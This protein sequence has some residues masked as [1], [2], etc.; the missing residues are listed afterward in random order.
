[1]LLLLRG[2][3][4]LFVTIYSYLSA[5]LPPFCLFLFVCF[6]VLSPLCLSNCLFLSVCLSVSVCFCVCMFLSIC[7]SVS[8]CLFLCLS[9][10]ISVPYNCHHHHLLLLHL[11]SL[12]EAT[13]LEEAKRSW[14]RNPS[15]LEFG[16]FRSQLA[17]FQD[18]DKDETLAAQLTE[19]RRRRHQRIVDDEA[20]A[21]QAAKA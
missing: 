17:R 6:C 16:F 18:P 11:S 9:V 13:P 8:V 1:M 21:T 7:L 3:P 19:D 14:V 5:C 20:A 15:D 10:S 2:P 12:R 4:C